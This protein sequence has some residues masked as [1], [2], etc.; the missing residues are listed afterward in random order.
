MKIRILGFC[1][2]MGVA[3]TAF[4]QSKIDFNGYVSSMG[5]SVFNKDSATWDLIIHNRLNFA[6]YA[7]DNFTVKVQGR[8]Q[9][10][11][12]ESIALTPNY[13]ESFAEDKGWLN[14]NFNWFETDNSL[15]N[16]QI[17]RAYVEY[18]KGN[19]EVSLGR[20][21]VNWGRTLVWNP[22]DIFNAFSYYDFDYMERPGSDAIR[23]QYYTGAASSVEMV[24]KI[25]SAEN[26][27]VAVMGKINKWGYDIQLLGGYAN[28]EDF[29]IGAG[30][31]GSIKSFGFR[32][33]MTY[34][35]PQNDFVDT[36]GSFLASIS[37]DYL[38]PKSILAQFE[39]LYND[40][41]NL[42][43][44]SQASSIFSAPPSS[45]NLSF[46]EYNFFGNLSWPVLPI[47]TI[48]LS[49]MYYTD[50]QGYFLMPGVDLSLG[51]NLYFSLIYQYFNFKVEDPISQKSFRSG[52][53]LAFARLKW[54]F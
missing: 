26:V 44:L 46:S 15:L 18:V 7:S 29:V 28:S 6:W 40:P 13:A 45:K 5:Q 49:G 24:A 48:N 38:L 17:D 22:N 25:D 33:E 42:L 35:H 2:L 19:F 11:W 31:E 3:S 21:R 41:K 36:S 37:F 34:Y 50:Y 54:S 30:W 20:Q 43:D 53:N 39:F 4:S 14:L 10:L 51:D 27:T 47:L 52:T 16:T 9:F 32:G 1:I 12:G 23:M 8:N